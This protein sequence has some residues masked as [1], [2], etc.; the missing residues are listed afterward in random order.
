M[1]NKVVSLYE[2]K[3]LKEKQLKEKVFETIYDFYI[4]YHE[5]L[6]WTEVCTYANQIEWN[7]FWDEEKNEEARE[8]LFHFSMDIEMYQEFGYTLEKFR[9][10]FSYFEFFVL[11]HVLKEMDGVYSDFPKDDIRRYIEFLSKILN[12]NQM[13]YQMLEQK[14]RK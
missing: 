8:F 4:P 5:V 14:V 7:M 6:F 1:G 12:K 2:R 9:F 13:F 10:L 11:Y 3:M